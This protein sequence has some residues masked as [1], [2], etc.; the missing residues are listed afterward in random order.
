MADNPD[1]VTKVN[2]YTP[3][4]FRDQGPPFAILLRPT[5]DWS[6]ED[7]SA[8]G[9]VYLDKKT[10]VCRGVMVLRIEVDGENY[11][12]FEVQPT[13]PDKAEY[14]GV[15]MK[16]HVS[17]MEEFDEFVQQLCSQVR[18]VV[19]RFKNMESFFPRGTKIF[20]HHQKDAKVLYRSRLINAFKEINVVLD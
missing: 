7:K 13:K 20:K 5:I 3:P 17:T 12:C 14:S 8:P 4:K 19:G 15:L 9:W 18:Y 1:R 11:F 2:W 16:S 6:P 10:G